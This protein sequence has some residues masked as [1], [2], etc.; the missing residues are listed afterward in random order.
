[1]FKKEGKGDA[2]ERRGKDTALLHTALDVERFGHSA[3]VLNGCFHVIMERSNQTVQIRGA[4]DIQEDVE[5]P[6]LANQ[7]RFDFYL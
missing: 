6:I 2:K 1:M 4:T 5:K 7:V 3:F